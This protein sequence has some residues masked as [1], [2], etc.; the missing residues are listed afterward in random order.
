MDADTL[1]TLRHVLGRQGRDVDSEIL[2]A[3]DILQRNSTKAHIVAR[4]LNHTLEIQGRAAVGPHHATDKVCTPARAVAVEDDFGTPIVT[5]PAHTSCAFVSRLTPLLHHVFI[6]ATLAHGADEQL[7]FTGTSASSLRRVPCLDQGICCASHYPAEYSTIAAAASASVPPAVQRAAIATAEAAVRASARGSIILVS[8]YRGLYA[9]MNVTE[10]CVRSHGLGAPGSS[11]SGSSGHGVAG[12]GSA[13]SAG[14][15]ADLHRAVSEELRQM[16]ARAHGGLDA[17]AAADEVVDA[18][19]AGATAAASS[20]ARHTA[21][22]SAAASP[23]PSELDMLDARCMLGILEQSAAAM[24][25]R[26][27]AESPSTSHA[28]AARSLPDADKAATVAAAASLGAGSDTMVA[29][30]T[31]SLLIDANGQLLAAGRRLNAPAEPTAAFP[32]AKGSERG[33]EEPEGPADI[34]AAARPD[35]PP[36]EPLPVDD[37]ALIAALRPTLKTSFA[38]LSHL[39]LRKG[40]LWLPFARRVAGNLLLVEALH[41]HAEPLRFRA[42]EGAAGAAP[43]GAGGAVDAASVVFELRQLL[44]EACALQRRI[45]SHHAAAGSASVTPAAAACAAAALGV[46]PAWPAAGPRLVAETRPMMLTV[47]KLD[48]LKEARKRAAAA[49]AVKSGE[50]IPPVKPLATHTLLLPLMDVLTTCTASGSV[51]AA[52]AAASGAS[53]VPCTFSVAV[54]LPLLSL[55]CRVV[56]SVTRAEDASMLAHV[57]LLVDADAAGTPASAG[58]SLGVP[59]FFR[60]DKRRVDSDGGALSVAGAG[61]AGVGNLATHLGLEDAS[62]SAS[63]RAHAGLS[64][65]PPSPLRLVCLAKLGPQLADV[66]IE[67][68]AQPLF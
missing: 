40:S 33:A 7:M 18:E 21:L 26:A 35:P 56:V 42:A 34:S 1:A 2:A 58:S 39:R 64:L 67:L 29:T 10:L 43:A 66:Q 45:A 46:R 57:E 22:L 62:P 5:M 55:T 47:C 25:L 51:P 59:L 23:K 8:E 16:T 14:I 38:S 52:S 6:R 50:V 53:A 13:R 31:V 32:S 12:S 44:L 27:D 28:A 3:G 4:R 49:A 19:A 65:L 36:R 15:V 30:A 54:P 61:S 41:G 24:Q 37:M 63:Y 20:P 60:V 68:R 48:E 9:E 11:G 17:S